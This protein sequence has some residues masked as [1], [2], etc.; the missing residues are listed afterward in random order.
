[1]GYCISARLDSQQ[2][3][4]KLCT[5]LNAIF[6]LKEFEDSGVHISSDPEEHGYAP[7]GIEPAIYVSYS[8]LPTA[9]RKFLWN[10]LKYASRELTTDFYYDS[11]KLNAINGPL[12]WKFYRIS[13]FWGW[14]ASLFE[15][16]QAKKL[17]RYQK[18]FNTCIKTIID[19]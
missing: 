17:E 15:K 19:E 16:T 10:S 9:T 13:G 6:D 8:T 18:V 3:A 4:E 12:R 2:R 1:M 14:V 5:E 7:D 11:E